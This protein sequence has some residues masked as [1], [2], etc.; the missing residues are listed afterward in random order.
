M[1]E[2]SKAINVAKLAHGSQKRKYTGRPYTD[3]LVEVTQIIKLFG[4]TNDQICGAILHDVV[5]DTPMSL[6]Q[7]QKI[8]NVNV[9]NYVKYLTDI[10]SPLAGNRQQRKKLDRERI[11]KAPWQAKMIKLADLISNTYNITEYDPNFAKVYL[12]EKELLLNESLEPN[13]KEFE[14]ALMSEYVEYRKLFNLAQD[15]LIESIIKLK[16][17]E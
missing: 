11:K 9:V 14:L 8:F 5:E 17:Y 13:I 15:V 2:I 16:Q 10:S 1:N 7:L 4:G 12:R 6:D 3:H